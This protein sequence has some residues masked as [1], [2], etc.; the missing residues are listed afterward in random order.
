M[1]AKTSKPISVLSKPVRIDLKALSSAVVQGVVNL[2]TGNLGELTS[3]SAA[4]LEAVGLKVTNAEIGWR[5]ILNS[6][7]QAAKTMLKEAYNFDSSNA[8]YKS[9]ANAFRTALEDFPVDLDADFFDHPRAIPLLQE[10]KPVFRDWLTNLGAPGSDSELLSERFPGYF[11]LALH[12]EWGTN[13]SVYNVLLETI[14]TPFAKQGIEAQQWTRYNQWLQQQLDQPVFTESFSLQQIFVPLRG[15][16]IEKMHQKGHSKLSESEENKKQRQHVV[17]LEDHL[18]IWLKKDDKDDAIRLISGGPGSG[19]SSLTKV[20]AARVAKE[21]AM[22]V[23]FIPLHRL[24]LSNDLTDAIN[25]F[26]ERDEF[27]PDTILPKKPT[28]RILLIFD[29]LDELAMQGKSA[30]AAALEFLN[31]VDALRRNFNHAKCNLKIVVAGREVV[32]QHNETLFRKSGQILHVL[33]YFVSKSEN[34]R[35][36]FIEPE[37]YDPKKLLEVDQRQIWWVKYGH[38]I[39]ER[40]IKEMPIEL[41]SDQLTE[42]TSQPLLNY[43][44]AL[45]L[46]RGKLVFDQNTNLNQVY[47]DL[48][49]SIYERGWDTA[50]TH[51]AIKR[52]EL[53]DFVRIL[54]EI[55]ICSWHGNGRT[56]TIAAIEKR[57]ESSGL[58]HVIEKYVETLEND[59]K[60]GITNLMT[61]FYFRQSPDINSDKT[62]EFTH[63]SFGEYL[64]ARRFV[65]TMKRINQKW[66]LFQ[67]H[68][69]DGW[70]EIKCLQEFFSMSC[71]TAIDTYVLQFLRDEMK[72]RA[73][74]S[75]L[76]QIQETFCTLISH[77]LKKGLLVDQLIQG[78]RLPFQEEVVR[79]R[80][81]EEALFVAVNLCARLTHKLAH[82]NFPSF[83]SMGNVIKRIAEQRDTAKNPALLDCLSYWDFNNCMLVFVDLYGANLE[84]TNLMNANLNR[85]ILA[86]T[87]LRG[88]NLKGAHLMGTDLRETNLLETDLEGA[89]LE[90]AYLRRADLRRTNL[91][92][93][94]FKE[95]DLENADL[96]GADLAGVLNLPKR[97]QINDQK[98]NI[99]V[100]S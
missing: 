5:L 6:L 40:S 28:E 95:A 90:G 19:K 58:K 34:L 84:K 97:H 36:T 56:T 60:A 44:V 83:K 11:S 78:N 13:P 50:E 87:N 89:N 1:P 47:E 39:G 67:K 92:G 68:D 27:L 2:A 82:V 62:F 15:Y 74:T 64:I 26:A 37:Y 7:I 96:Y 23:V 22:R 85:A 31:Q 35:H 66:N 98:S 52:I 61:A 63:K 79:A 41:R 57:F 77:V 86:H 45:S 88:A 53:K 69:E 46:R 38:C 20:F 48:L 33:P 71:Q 70:S 9:L 32:V 16:F 29:G 93:A 17:M 73:D 42:I 30:T 65:A 8:D 43:L 81:T 59:P 99:K 12:L 3:N 76:L 54:E 80:N 24:T 10:V 51:Q 55:A 94:N 14:N 72:Q 25:T 21:S 18:M 100:K 75:E 49:Q 4:T 91:E